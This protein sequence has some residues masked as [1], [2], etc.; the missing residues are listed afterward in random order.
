[1]GRFSPYLVLLGGILIASSAAILFKLAPGNNNALLIA[2]GRLGLASL[3]VVPL[4]G[5]RAG[6]EL[7]A[8][9]RREWGLMTLSGCFLALHFASWFGSLQYTS[10]VSSTTLVATTPIWVGLAAWLLWRE[11]MRRALMTGMLIALIGSVL[12]GWSD[13]QGEQG[14]APLLGDLLALVGAWG[15]AGYFLAGTVVRRRVDILPYIAG[16]YSVAALV[17][18]VWALLAGYSFAGHAPL[19]YAVM[20][21]LALGPQLL[22]HTAFNWSLRYLSPT[23]VTLATLGEPIGSSLL[24][25]LILQQVPQPLQ[26]VGGLVL[27]SGIVVATVGGRPAQKQ[28]VP[29]A[30]APIDSELF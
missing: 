26:I 10:V 22:G 4:A 28:A 30:E 11:R 14:A 8:V 2:A 13:G 12:I 17:L 20:A 24:A 25:L 7:R 3:V 15:A 18:I 16:T 1:M 23:V 6:A 21:G 9:T 5:A 19:L 27:L 29:L